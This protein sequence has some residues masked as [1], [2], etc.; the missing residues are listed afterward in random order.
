MR[1]L[2]EERPSDA[3]FDQMVARSRDQ[4]L[5]SIRGESRPW[6]RRMSR[7]TVIA[8][9]VVAGGVA[10]GAYAATQALFPSP[11][12]VIAGGSTVVRLDEPA[13][14]DKWLNVGIVYSCGSG[15]SFTLRNGDDIIFDVDCDAMF[16]GEDPA[17]GAGGGRGI[18]DSIPVGDVHGRA[19]TLDSNL[20]HDYR[21][22]ASF[23]PTEEMQPLVLP[24]RGADGEVDWAAPDYEVNEYGL[25][26]G[27]PKA[28]TPEDQWPDLYPVMFEGREA[29]FLGEEMNGPMP[30]NLDEM[31][32][33]TDEQR[34]EGLVD[35]KGNVYRK[36]YAAD[37][38]TV[39]GKKWIGTVS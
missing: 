2:V 19:L 5:K 24:G 16:P 37:G 15:E 23:G 12:E 22:E 34:R 20:S 26:V 3:E 10:G 30:M 31:K 27:V 21:I 9:I 33:R 6:W 25:T 4:L 11:P 17:I 14:G 1:D 36:V 28:N 18:Y 38:K 32:K 7:F 13:P 8:S 39:L 35:D 29:Y